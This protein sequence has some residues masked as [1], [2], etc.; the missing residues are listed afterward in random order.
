MIWVQAANN[1][2][3]PR[4]AGPPGIPGTP[5]APGSGGTSPTHF[6][7]LNLAPGACDGLDSLAICGGTAPLCSVNST[8]LGGQILGGGRA[9]GGCTPGPATAAVAG[10]PPAPPQVTPGVALTALRE[11]GLPSLTVHTQPEDKTLVNFATIFYAEPQPFTRTVTLLGQSVQ[12]EATPTAYAWNYGDGTAE[13]TGMP[14]APYPRTDVTHLYRD[15]HL[16][17]SPRVDVTYSGRF[18][19]AAGAWQ[20]IPGT[21]TITGP[22]TSLRISEATPLLSG[23][24][25]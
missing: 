18:R 19:V 20:D 17:V 23:A 10:G 8:V 3:G 7:P 22:N 11:I 1:M 2:H 6:V 25:S 5:G 4:H 14:G 15:A 13:T 9:P 21:V 16:T 24:L 12:L